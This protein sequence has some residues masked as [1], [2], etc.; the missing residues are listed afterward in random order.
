M[1][2]RYRVRALIASLLLL[3]CVSFVYAKD[4]ARQ[5]YDRALAMEEK[6][7]GSPMEKQIDLGPD[8][9]AKGGMV[10]ATG[11]PEEICLNK[12]SITGKYLKKYLG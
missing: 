10:V 2:K 12:Q 6:L 3:S 4:D 5:L 1:I 11:T 8:G 9:G 7:K